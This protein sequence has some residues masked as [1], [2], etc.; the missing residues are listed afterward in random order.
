M[1]SHHQ[2]KKWQSLQ[3]CI[4]KS[5][6]AKQTS[7]SC[8]FAMSTK[9]FAAGKTISSSFKIVAP[10]FEIVALPLLSA[11]NLS[12]PLGPR[13]VRTE[14]ATTWH[15]WMLLM[16]WR[17]PCACSVPSFNR[18]IGRDCFKWFNVSIK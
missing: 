14:S 13:V 12:I 16:I 5:N 6:E 7:A 4:G 8:D 15:A 3:Y 9:V 10:S 11:I 17:L 1:L 2:P 18:I